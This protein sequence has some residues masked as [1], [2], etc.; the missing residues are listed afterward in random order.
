M[1]IQYT[2]GPTH[3]WWQ[4]R[5]SRQWRRFWGWL[6]GPCWT[7][8][9][10]SLWPR[11]TC[12]VSFPQSTLVCSGPGPS[13]PPSGGPSGGPGSTPCG[14]CGRAARPG[15]R[16]GG[17]CYGPPPPHLTCCCS[18]PTLMQ[19][20]HM[21]RISKLGKD[22]KPHKSHTSNQSCKHMHKCF[23]CNKISYT[24]KSYFMRTYHWAGRRQKKLKQIIENATE[25]S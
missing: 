10:L 21:G 22:P 12:P 4:G 23:E 16:L 5:S 13:G 19:Y 14:G 9:R 6:C 20:T 15:S 25:S 1:S 18:G 2:T 17:W 7:H 11:G 24:I 3:C 8:C